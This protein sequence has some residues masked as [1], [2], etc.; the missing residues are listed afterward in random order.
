MLATD[1]LVDGLDKTLVLAAP[2]FLVVGFGELL[3]ATD[4]FLFL[5]ASGFF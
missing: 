3:L 1:L 4:K 5:S 2:A